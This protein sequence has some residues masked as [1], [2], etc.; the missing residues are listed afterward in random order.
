[1][2][3]KVRSFRSVAGRLLLSIGAAAALSSSS[4]HVT[5]AADQAITGAGRE[6]AP[7]AAHQSF[8]KL[9]DG[10]GVIHKN[11]K[12]GLGK[13]VLLEFPRD[14]RDVLVSNPATVDA[15][16]L[17]ANRVFLLARNPGE[18]NAFFFDSTGEQFATMEL[19]IDR[20]TA[21]LESLLNRLIPG[22]RI[23]IE[24]LN[25]T[26]ILTGSVRNPADSVRAAT[27]AA[28]FAVVDFDVKAQDVTQ[29]TAVST[30]QSGGSNTGNGTNESVVNMLAVEAEEQV[31]LSVTVAE[32]Q[33]EVLKQFGVNLGNSINVGNFATTLLTENALPLTAA[34][35]LGVLPTF[36]LSTATDPNA[37][38]PPGQ[39]CGFGQGP[40]T[41]ALGNSGAIGGWRDPNTGNAV[42]G[43]IRALERTGLV[44]TLAEPNL[45]AISGESA[46]FLAG[47]EYPVPTVDTVGALGVTFKEFGIG[48]AFTPIVLS[49]G[50]ISLK[51]ETEVSELTNNGAVTLSGIQIPAIKKRQ[52]R[53]TVELP[54]GGTL[55]FAGLI[56]DDLRQNV[57]G[58]P[59]LKDVP[60]LGTLFRSR[61][62]IKRETELVVIV[63]P[64]LVK[65]AARQQIATPA[66]GLAAAT[67][68]KANFL[69]HLNRV[70]GK[71]EAQ[72]EGGL[73]GDYGF[74]VE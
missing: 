49:E 59:G 23:K 21:G 14:V 1:M 48:L 30:S 12:I 17:S 7:L 64:Y 4:A 5:V 28:Q 72:P 24:V 3:I 39:V 60:I 13:S 2:S 43:A 42:R 45:T 50:R 52:A 26:V 40:G 69:G 46:K 33:R 15:V 61:D 66:D 22:S 16:V 71:S 31:T 73:K 68:L 44:R 56:S 29:G 10:Q 53:S 62:Y 47:G 19:Y 51:I 35:G 20:E 58:F 70:Y 27:I 74:I 8:V 37:S 32:V 34:A 25:K 9:E 57:D 38:C 65:P 36:G 11:L 18:A 55:A 67:D 41:D 63:T 54:S 6:I